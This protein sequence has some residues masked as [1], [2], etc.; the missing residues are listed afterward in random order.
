MVVDTQPQLIVDQSQVTFQNQQYILQDSNIDFREGQT[1][2][3][4]YYMDETNSQQVESIQAEQVPQ[5]I[6]LNHQL[7]G[8][9]VLG[10]INSTTTPKIVMSLQRQNQI[11][12]LSQPLK[13]VIIYFIYNVQFIHLHYK[14]WLYN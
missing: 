13:Q 8:T 3:Q 10:S 11:N 4:I 1:Q 12:P 2:Q 9:Q 5:T 6:V 7:S 14:Q